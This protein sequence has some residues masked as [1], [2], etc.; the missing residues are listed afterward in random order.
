MNK[1]KKIILPVV[2]IVFFVATFLNIKNQY[3]TLKKARLKNEELKVALEKMKIKKQQLIKKIEYATSSAYI[4]QQRRELLALG[5]NGDVWLDLPKNE[6]KIG[7][8]VEVNETKAESNWQKW[9]KLF[10]D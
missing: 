3:S 2:A 6:E 4:D 1:L 5:N 9:I 7:Y 10:T 8:K